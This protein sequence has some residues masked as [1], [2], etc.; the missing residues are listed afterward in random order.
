ML[1]VI[2]MLSAVMQ[3]VVL[4]SVV[5]LKVV[6][7]TATSRPKQDQRCLVIFLQ[8]FAEFG[9]WF[10]LINFCG[11][12]NCK[13]FELFVILFIYLKLILFCKLK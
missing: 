5:M 4:L 10:D 7:L 6:A 3:S 2:I 8:K 13:L 11:L 1:N 9:C 12:L